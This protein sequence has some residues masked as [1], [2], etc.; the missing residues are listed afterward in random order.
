MPD[1]QNASTSL[2]TGALTIRKLIQQ[3]FSF[4]AAK[5]C[6]VASVKLGFAAHEFV[7]G[8]G[9]RRLFG[10]EDVQFGGLRLD[11]DSVKALNLLFKVFL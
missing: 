10:V 1:E 6:V 5:I 4:L 3:S 11:V 7:I 2:V 8:P 9:C